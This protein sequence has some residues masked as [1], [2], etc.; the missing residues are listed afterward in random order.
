[1]ATIYQAPDEVGKF[2][3]DFSHYNAKDYQ[4]K[5]KQYETKLKNW[6]VARCERG[7]KSTESVGEILYFPVADGY[8]CYMVA[9]LKPLQLIHL[10]VG[11]AWVF[12]Y[13]N[14]LTLK[15]V[16]EKIKANKKLAE[17]FGNKE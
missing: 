15:D 4:L 11:D 14:R 8:A 16:K 10:E 6:L 5:L 3:Y 1:M 7:E 12:E 13:A 2:E 9:C 17:I